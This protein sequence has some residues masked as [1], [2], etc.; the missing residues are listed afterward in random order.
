MKKILVILLF[1]PAFSFSQKMSCCKMSS[2]ESF[3]I[4]SQDADFVSEHLSPL[5]FN[6]VPVLG[7]MQNLKCA[8][9]ESTNAFIVKSKIASNNWLFIFHEWWGLN[10]YIKQEAEKI[11]VELPN[12]NIIALDLYD[13]SVA[14]DPETA[15][16]LMEKTT[17]K[18]SREIINCAFEYTGANAKIVT[19]GWCMGGGWSLQA[20]LIAGKKANGC[21]MYYGMPEPDIEKLKKLET[22]VLGIFALKDEW[23]TTQV[24][25]D[26]E[27]NMKKAG[28]TLTVKNYDTGHAFANPS[29]PKFDKQAS[30]DAY[31]HMINYLKSKMK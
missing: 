16:G 23:I 4:L 28:K 7:E 14:T 24:V 30:S 31:A 26:F 5:P 6:F 10:D 1:I 27:L 3:A 18:R 15:K 20:S 13:G 9:G 22:D 2:T 29:N 19:L 8:T 21:V 12:V 11:A 25:A 17:D